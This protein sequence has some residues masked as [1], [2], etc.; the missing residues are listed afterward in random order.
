MSR[1]EFIMSKIQGG[2]TM[3]DVRA[4]IQ[5]LE[6]MYDF[7]RQCVQVGCQMFCVELSDNPTKYAPS[8]VERIIRGRVERLNK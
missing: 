3:H 4:L 5:Q 8:T 7:E 6:D 1:T 2:E